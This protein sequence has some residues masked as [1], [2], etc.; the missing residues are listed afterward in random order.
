MKQLIV[1]D[2][3]STL[4]D[5]ETLDVLAK[6]FGV[7]KKIEKITKQAMNG[8]IN[9]EESV[10]K[11]L[12]LLKD[13]PVN[14]IVN[15]ARS[16]PLMPGAKQLIKQLKNKGFLIGIITG[17]YDIIAK[18]IV[19]R[20]NLDFF[21]ANELE[22]ENKKLTGKFK[23]NVNGNKD[24]LL[25]NFKEHFQAEVTISVG[26]GANDIPMLKE[27]DIGIAFC[28]KPVVKKMIK[29]KIN[30]KNLMEVLNFIP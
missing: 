19:K 20:L 24:L 21:V 27:A 28:A 6:G 13:L 26:D 29:N 15:F 1:F 18:I 25:R 3:D 4:I 10:E 2:M 22:I 5:C 30:E 14:M 11:R 7:N 12:R 16:C 9:F 8:E 17:S 23:L